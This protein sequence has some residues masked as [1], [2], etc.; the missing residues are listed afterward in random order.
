MWWRRFWFSL[1]GKG[2][3]QRS[4]E[5]A[6]FYF[7]QLLSTNQPIRAPHWRDV[8]LAPC[9]TVAAYAKQTKDIFG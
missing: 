4:G 9:N 2:E 1:N 8:G 6:T 7:A 3:I 5:G